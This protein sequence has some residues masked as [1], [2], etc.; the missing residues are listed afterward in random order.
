[1]FDALQVVIGYQFRDSALLERALTTPACRMDHPNTLDNQRLEFLGDAVLGLLAADRIFRAH[2]DEN[3]GALT[4]RRTRMIST[5][6][7]IAVANVL[8]LEKVLKRNA[9]AAP[10]TPN[11]KPLADAV[12][13][14]LGAAWL[15]GGLAAAQKVFDALPFP[16]NQDLP[17]WGD[18][19]KGYL[20]YRAQSLRP[21]RHPHYEV[22]ETTGPDH[23]PIV[24][25]RVSVV[26]LGE[27]TATAVTQHAA[28]VAAAEALLKKLGWD[29]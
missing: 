24:T 12:E 26:T 23:A 4:V 25:V 14:I 17:P 28:E 2:K 1:M 3:E 19:P 7:L 20:Q 6:A 10:L 15:D 13:A 22:V 8:H 18:N 21:A 9:G 5:A 16:T 11:A 29:N 27:A